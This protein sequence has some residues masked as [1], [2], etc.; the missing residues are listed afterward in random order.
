MATKFYTIET[1]SISPMTV[2][3]T[4]LPRWPVCAA[5]TPETIHVWYNGV[6]KLFKDWL[7]ALTAEYDTV[8]KAGWKA[9]RR[10]WK[11]NDKYFR[12]LDLPGELRNK[13]YEHALGGEIYPLSTVNTAQMH[14]PLGRQNA[15]LILG[16]GYNYKMVHGR[17]AAGGSLAHLVPGRLFEE[18][19]R[20][21]IWEPN[22]ALLRVSQ[23]VR[24]EVLYQGWAV[25]R[26]R[27]F[28]PIIFTAAVDARLGSAMRYAYLSC[29]ELGFD[30]KQYFKFFGAC[31]D[32][33]FHINTQSCFAQHLLNLPGVKNLQ[34]R[35]R[36]LEEG[37][38][39]SPWD[40]M[41]RKQDLARYQ[42]YPY[43]CCQRTMVDWICTFAYPFVQGIETV[44]VA[45]NAKTT[46]KQEWNAIFRGSQSH[47]Q[48]AEMAAILTTP[49]ALL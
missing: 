27:F 24:D 37:W 7:P 9:L 8:G 5:P 35:F 18:P 13:I 15:R 25:M 34:L 47:D 19:C 33:Q 30:N 22:L 12:I 28:H 2:P 44:M 23:Q 49:D 48:A 39:S 16:A 31:L 38:S 26:K 17:Y 32:R 43:E 45:G 14:D 29:I 40:G 20:R 41:P 10:M 1:G 46:S 4:V 6:W 11:A 3:I 36:S 42:Q 21:A